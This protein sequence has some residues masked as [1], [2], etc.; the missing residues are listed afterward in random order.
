MN[1]NREQLPTV[2]DFPV[3]YHH[4]WQVLL[5]R[6]NHLGLNNISGKHRTK[7]TKF[8]KNLRKFQNVQKK[9]IIYLHKSHLQH[10]LSESYTS[11]YY[12]IKLKSMH[13]FHHFGV[14]I[15]KLFQYISK[16][17]KAK[18]PQW[19]PPVGKELDLRFRFVAKLTPRTLNSVILTL[20]N[21][22]TLQYTICF[23][24]NWNTK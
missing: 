13:S 16:Q 14:Q 18:Q 20:N 3:M 21:V 12:K 10:H 15:R 2:H 5:K 19:I 17:L 24:I 8:L 9:D 11:L 1:R 22:R 4:Q 7:R 6:K 23:S